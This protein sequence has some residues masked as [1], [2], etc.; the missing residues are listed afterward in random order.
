MKHHPEET[1]VTPPPKNRSKVGGYADALM[2]SPEDSYP[3][4]VEKE[5]ILGGP[6]PKPSS[7]SKHSDRSQ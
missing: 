5:S 7:I 1:L 2:D 6:A 3:K 4:P